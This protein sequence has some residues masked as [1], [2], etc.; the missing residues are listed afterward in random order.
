MVALLVLALVVTP[1]EQY[2]ALLKQYDAPLGVYHRDLPRAKAA[3]RPFLQLA[4]DH[5]DD[6]TAVDALHWIVTHTFLPDEAGQAMDLLVRD[7]SQSERLGPI[8]R[9]LDRQYGSTFK[10]LENLFRAVLANNPNREARGIACLALARRLKKDRE[11]VECERL[12]HEAESKGRPLPWVPRPK[13]TD[14]ELAMVGR[15]SQAL[16]QRVIDQFGDIIDDS[17][18]LGAAA[19][20]ERPLSIGQIAREIEGEDLDGKRFKLS[21][22]RGKVVVLNFWNHEGCAVCRGAYPEERALVERMEGKPFVMLGINNGDSP[23]ALRKLRE[24][25][26]VTWRFWVDGDLSEGKI[27]KHWNV[28]AW[29]TIIVLDR[30]GV[31]RYQGFWMAQIPLIEYAV[32]KLLNDQGTTPNR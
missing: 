23:E 30:E 28:H 11:I 4:R 5:P 8:C 27:I 17:G 12:Q 26:E 25:G 7:H 16:Y 29:P 18:T 21:D 13:L 6:P 14:A 15:E 22:F 19:T 1:R 3:C 31:I 9:E 32:E 2:E 24:S 20:I 10:P